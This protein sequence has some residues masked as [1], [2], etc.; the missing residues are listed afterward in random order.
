MTLL[1]LAWLVVVTTTAGYLK[2]FSS[3]PK[4]GFLAHARMLADSVAAGTLPRG[5]PSAGAASQMIFND[6]L[7]A[8]V[9]GFFLASVLVILVAS[10]AEWLAVLGGRKAPRSTEVPFEP[11]TAYAGD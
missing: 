10:A 4:L 5:V 8:A 11:R 1:P 2:I 9:A 7:D 3:D 6:R